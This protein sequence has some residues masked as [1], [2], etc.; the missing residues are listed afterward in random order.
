MVFGGLPTKH[1]YT[2]PQPTILVSDVGSSSHV[3]YFQQLQPWLRYVTYS[4][5]K[6]KKM[7]SD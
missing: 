7:G 5:K 6:G 4:T 3:K 1:I 2:S